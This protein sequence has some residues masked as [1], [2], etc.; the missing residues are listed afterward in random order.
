MSRPTLLTRHARLLALFAPLL[1][2][3]C[4]AEVSNTDT[5]T[6]TTR[7]E[8]DPALDEPV[9]PATLLD[10]GHDLPA[11]FQTPLVDA[12]DNTPGDNQITDAGATLGRVLFW[13]RQLSH[14]R[15][16][17]CGSC[18]EPSTG[19]SDTATL[20]EGFA[21]DLTG[22]N[23][24]PL[25]N[26]RWYERGAMFWDERADT[27]E[28]QVLMPIQDTAE[29]G[30]TLD[31]LVTRVGSTDYYAPLFEAAFGD[32][33]VSSE[34]ISLALAQFVRSIASYRSAWD[35]GVA[36]VG[37]DVAQDLPNFTPQ[38]N[39]GKDLFFGQ[40][41]CGGC[42]M[43]G[44]P[45]TPPPPGGQPPPLDNLALW[46]VGEP[47]NN[48]L[49]DA[50][51]DGVGGTTGL[52]ADDGKFKSPSLRNVAL[53]GPYMHDGRFA[54]L[55]EV[56]EHYN[57]GIEAHPNLDPRLRDPQSG[58]PIRLN[59]SPMDRA[60]LVAFLGTLTDPTLADDPR[61]SDPF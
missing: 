9:L 2:V 12:A 49:I 43:P 38:Q 55:A 20:S 26:L 30:L 14:N 23:S 41:R 40:G 44:S 11:H 6:D 5:G 25:A 58:N 34:R 19:F 46:F 50:S 31:E 45:L 29:M 18:H 22:R 52:A 61:W 42:H 4:D 48:G 7:N 32:A 60:A 47:V 17:A 21:G 37:G 33:T 24:M 27:L 36:L 56:V 3:A 51:D 16:V 15:T 39:R 13:D 53:T 10:Y 35:E 59:L 57:S 54:T 1:L 28:D 8:A